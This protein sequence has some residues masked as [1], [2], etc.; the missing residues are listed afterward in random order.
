MFPVFSIRPFLCIINVPMSQPAFRCVRISCR[1]I[2]TR[3]N[4]SVGG[5]LGIR[6]SSENLMASVDLNLHIVFPL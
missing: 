4:D 3:F 5:F 2:F 6:P 1:A